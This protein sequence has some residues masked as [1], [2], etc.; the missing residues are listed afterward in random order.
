MFLLRQKVESVELLA[1]SGKVAMDEA[2]KRL[3][4]SLRTEPGVFA[5]CYVSSPVGEGVGRII[6]DPYSHLLFSNRIE[7]NAPLD[8]LRRAGYSI[9]EAITELLR[10]RGHRV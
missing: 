1:R 6:L 8:E 2:K 7:D 3:V 9:D 5:E 10:R 4:Q